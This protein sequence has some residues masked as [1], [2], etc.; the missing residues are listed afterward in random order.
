VTKRLERQDARRI[1]AEEGA[2]I[3]EIAARLGVSVSSVS[4]WVR[5]IEL[6]AAQQSALRER[7]PIHNR[8]VRGNA[9]TTLRARLRRQRW[10]DEG[11]ALARRGDPLHRAGCMLHWA[12]GSKR[13][14]AVCFVNSDVDMM[15]L[16]TRFLRECYDARDEQ[17]AFSVN[18]FLGNGVSLAEIERFWLAALELPDSC[19]RAAAVNRPSSASK[20]TGRTLVHGTGRLVMHSTAVAQSIYG[21]IQEYGGF[22]RPEWLD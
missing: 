11:R 19:L 22:E 1:R 21:A 2:S 8:Q 14:N 4:L 17:L 20:R 10:Q 5:N 12:E 3:R 9:T 7:N 6:T 18:C 15:R 13:R 16:F